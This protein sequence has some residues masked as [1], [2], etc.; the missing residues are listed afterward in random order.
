MFILFPSFPFDARR[1]DSG[2]EA[3]ELAAREAGFQTAYVDLEL[4]T[5]PTPKFHR[6]PAETG[7]TALYR[8]WLMRPE[9]YEAMETALRTR[10][11]D[12]ATKLM[13]YREAYE[14]PFWA[15]KLGD[16]T[17]RSLFFEGRTFEARHIEVIASIVGRSFGNKPILVKDFL[18]SRKHEWFDACFIKPADDP[19]E[20]IRVVTNFV[21]GQGTDLSGGLVFREFVEF[22]RAGIHPKSRMPLIK[23]WRIFVWQHKVLYVAPY[24]ADASYA[25]DMPEIP[26]AWL[27]DVI[28]KLSSP[29][30]VLDVAKRLDGTVMVI[31]V[32]DAGAAGVPE[33]GSATEFYR[34]LASAGEGLP[35]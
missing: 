19:T 18:K 22:E 3:E 31:E 29:F 4:N 35:H 25:A 2:F 30:F 8:G 9:I 32:N 5:A 6:L 1:V 23:E 7:E 33:G 27:E 26:L 28:P 21:K 11:L 17:P 15:E 12:L 13:D 16:L 20:V 24:W 34:R 14:F 10:G